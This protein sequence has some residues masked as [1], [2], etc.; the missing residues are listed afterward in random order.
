MNAS[1]TY[2]AGGS[3]IVNATPEDRAGQE[4]RQARYWAM[5]WPE[6]EAAFASLTAGMCPA[7]RRGKDSPELREA[8]DIARRLTMARMNAEG[9]RRDPLPPPAK[10]VKYVA[11]KLR[12]SLS[13]PAISS[14]ADAAK[15]ASKFVDA[16]ANTPSA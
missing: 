8:G 1:S 13:R 3:I 15:F 10:P 14:T 12:F 5:F 16:V 6:F 4:A 7:P 9:L 11:P 2:F